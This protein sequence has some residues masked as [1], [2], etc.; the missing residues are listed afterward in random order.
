MGRFARKAFVSLC[1]VG[2]VAGIGSVSFNASADEVVSIDDPVMRCEGELAPDTGFSCE[3]VD[4]AVLSERRLTLPAVQATEGR[5]LAGC[6]AGDD[7]PTKS[8]TYNYSK[9]SDV[10]V[11]AGI[12]VGIPQG[13]GASLG[14]TVGES[15]SY[16]TS[17]GVTVTAKY[18]FLTVQNIAQEA[19]EATMRVSVEVREIA[20]DVP[21]STV[22]TADGAV[23][24]FPVVGASGDPVGSE[25]QKRNRFASADDFR[26]ICGADAVVPDYLGG[27]GVTDPTPDDPA[28]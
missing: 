3:V 17:A 7:Q 15:V 1:A 12:D 28:L 16:G 24:V 26:T 11:G 2:V 21:N 25:S 19:V 18:G 13:V 27:P 6:E 22:Y 20:A 10:S 8:L 5:G 9:S 4:T 23:K 14:V